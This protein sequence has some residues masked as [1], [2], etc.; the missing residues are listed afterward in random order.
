M[1]ASKGQNVVNINKSKY[2]EECLTLLNS[3]QFVWLIEDPTKTNERKVQGMLGKIKLN[4]AD[5]EYK[6]LYPN[7]SAPGKFYDT[8][9]VHK[10]LITEGVDKLPIRPIISN[11][12]TPTYQFAKCWAKLLSLL[13]SSKNTVTST[14]DFIEKVKM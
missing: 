10:I 12:G 8:A 3:E 6:R 13:T 9:K 14:K 7:G 1:K 5:Q 4:F 2:L 11:I